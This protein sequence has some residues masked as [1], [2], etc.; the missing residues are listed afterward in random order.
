MSVDLYLTAKNKTQREKMLG[1]MD[2]NFRPY[3]ALRREHNGEAPRDPE[4]DLRSQPYLYSDGKSITVG[5]SGCDPE[6]EYAWTLMRWMTLKIGKRAAYWKSY[7]HPSMLWFS[8]DH[9][10]AVPVNPGA[11]LEGFIEGSDAG[12]WM[13]YYDDLGCQTRPLEPESLHPDNIFSQWAA[14]GRPIIRAEIVRLNDLWM[15]HD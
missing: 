13:G 14:E 3:S 11:L 2:A 7:G 8:Y 4:T 9:Q 5:Y 12:S 15:A 10:E 6:R 1:F